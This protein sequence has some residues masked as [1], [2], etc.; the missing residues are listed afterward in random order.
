MTDHPPQDPRA[1][2]VSGPVPARHGA[3]DPSAAA[4]PKDVQSAPGFAPESA[5]AA[6]NEAPGESSI[7]SYAEPVRGPRLW[8]RVAGALILF[9]GAGGAWVWQNPASLNA[10]L[11]SRGGDDSAV[12]AL[13]ARVARLEQRPAQSDPAPLAARL[14]ALEKR[15][16]VSVSSPVSSPDPDLR[17]LVARLDALE[18]RVARDTSPVPSSATGEDLRPLLTRLDALERRLAEGA[19]D[20]GKVDAISSRV[21]ALSSRDPA[22]DLRARLDDLERQLGGLSAKGA[23]TA[24]TSDRAARQARLHA[25]VVA[26]AAGRPL[27]AIAGAP[28]ALTRFATAAPPVE[29]ALRLAFPAASRAALQA[30]LPDTEGKPFLDRV[31]ARLQDFR[32]VTVREGE[33]VLI[34]NSAVAILAR[35]QAQLDAGD[36]AGATL[37]AGKLLGP[38]A[39]KMAAWLADAKALVAA[40][41]ALASLTGN[42]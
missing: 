26:L 27:G 40:R 35:A 18:T 23:G 11:P 41:E 9:L 39:E 13:E 28:A 16:A 19:T 3:A 15:V 42:G 22:A 8:P 21:D 10:L 31:L 5:P 17:P 4:P 29:S 25:A 1:L 2:P 30:S 38:P 36:L 32:L 37:T 6:T 7:S 24:E 33:T 34:G 20:P 14:D 12:K